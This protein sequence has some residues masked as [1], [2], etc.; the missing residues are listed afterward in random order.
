MERHPLYDKAAGLYD[1]IYHWKDYRAEGGKLRT[2]LLAAGV[3]EGGHILEAACGTGAHLQNL[4]QWFR[5]S[6]FDRSPEMLAI[7][8]SKLPDVSLWQADMT[9]FSVAPPVDALLCLFSSIGYVYPEERLRQAARA[10]ADA[11]RPGGALI[12]EPFLTEKT[13]TAGHID[14]QT[15][16]S[17]ELKMARACKTSKRDSLAVLSFEWLVLT[18]KDSEIGHFTETHEMWLCPTETLLQAF[19]NAG[20]EARFEPE[21]LMPTRGLIL[22]RRRA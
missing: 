9:D 17:T 7:A 18:R 10:F 19:E 5:V 8:R 15:Y 3:A 2:L 16:E 6:G 22:G 13:F 20:F 11:V 1:R 4:S 12:V 14:L 21:G